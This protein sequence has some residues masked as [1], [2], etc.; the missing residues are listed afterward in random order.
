VTASR[1]FLLLACLYFSQGLPYGFL[2]K[3]TPLVMRQRGASLTEIGLISL[4]FLPWAF[5]FLWA[6]LTDRYGSLAYGRKKSWIVPLQCGAAILFLAFSFAGDLDGYAFLLAILF[7]ISLLSATQDTASDGLAVLILSLGERGLGNG[8]QVGFY[9]LGMIF[10]GGGILMAFAW[11]QW[12]GAFLLIGALLL[13]AT[14]PVMTAKEPAQPQFLE[15]PSYWRLFS[16]FFRRGGAWTWL[17]LI[18]FYKFGDAMT[19]NMLVPMV[20]DWG[21]EERAVGLLATVESSSALAGAFI[22]GALALWLGRFQALAA[23]GL[24]QAAVI[25]GYWLMSQGVIDREALFLLAAGENLCGS[26]ANVALFTVMM[27]V[28]DPRS[29]SSDFTLQSCVLVIAQIGSAIAG[30]MVAEALGYGGN[31][32]ISCL[33]AIAAPILLLSKRSFVEKAQESVFQKS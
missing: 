3:L 27:D 12:R 7:V 15:S 10:G 2:T 24:S 21:W 31:F 9:R 5:K 28:C 29:A 33:L 16:N 14:L 23:F 26:M 6:P 18:G 25:F 19:S 30:G 13:L 20:S 8:A 32:L 1:K 4:V 11:L 17:M 22:G